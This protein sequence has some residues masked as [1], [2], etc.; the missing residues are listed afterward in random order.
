[1]SDDYEAAQKSVLPVI[2][3]PVIRITDQFDLG[4][5]NTRDP[6]IDDPG[7]NT[8]EIC[9]NTFIFTFTWKVSPGSMIILLKITD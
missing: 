4:T 6:Y 1:M 2:Q 5:N 3:T 7:N 8:I 9:G